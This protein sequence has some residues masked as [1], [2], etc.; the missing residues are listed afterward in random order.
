MAATFSVWNYGTRQYDYFQAGEHDGTHITAGAPAPMLGTASVLGLTPE[1][2]VWP[3]PKFAVR[4]GSGTVAVGQ[5]AS[6]QESR[7]PSIRSWI[8]YGAIAY[9][10]WRALS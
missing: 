7:K 8:I 1:Q 10:V 9:A 3:L 5:V 2:F 4:S 6:T